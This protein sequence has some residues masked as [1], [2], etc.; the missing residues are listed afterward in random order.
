LFKAERYKLKLTK[1]LR[2]NAP[3]VKARNDASTIAS[4]N[5]L[6]TGN[7]IT[8]PQF[9]S[10]TLAE[11]N[12]STAV[13]VVESGE[14]AEPKV[15]FVEQQTSTPPEQ[16]FRI[17][18]W[19][20]A[21]RVHHWIKNLLLFVPLVLDHSSG[22]INTWLVTCAGFMLLSLCASGTYI[23]NDISD[24]DADRAHPQ[25]SH[26]PFAAGHLSVVTGLA[27]AGTLISISLAVAL[28]LSF[29]FSAL[30]LCYVLVTLLYTFRLKRLPIIDVA[31]LAALHTLRLGMG[32]A[33]SHA[34]M[35]GWLVFAGALAF[36][37]LALAKRH[38]EMIKKGTNSFDASI[39]GR[40]YS[41]P[42]I[43][44]TLAVGVGSA[45]VATQAAVSYL[46]ASS[47]TE[48]FSRTTL[49]W[50]IPALLC[51]WLIRV[52]L[53]A[54]RGELDEDLATFALR[55]TFTAAVAVCVLGSIAL[56]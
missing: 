47:P 35:P 39:S 33:L 51:T 32:I 56:A 7:V 24:L 53:F 31:T 12:A 40:G 26:R 38:S 9:T 27:V 25:K 29:V 55:D 2:E 1:Q 28:F 44:I 46:L 17:T 34:L 18:R 52:W 54:N 20:Q 14:P 13:G 15:R 42:D 16:F 45:L 3:Q 19:C 11:N 37:S 8:V 48:M 10:N 22:T 36:L 50:I 49:L 30:L 41:A 5:I 23:V 43:H 4:A 21:L 6:T